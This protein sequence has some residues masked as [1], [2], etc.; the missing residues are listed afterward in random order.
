[1][2]TNPT[3]S[4]FKKDGAINVPAARRVGHSL[5]QK[6]QSMTKGAAALEATDKTVLA[7]ATI[8]AACTIAVAA[9]ATGAFAVI[10]SGPFAAGALGAVGLLLAARNTY[11]NRESA[12]KTLQPYVWSYIDDETPKMIDNS[13]R[14]DVGAAAMSL[15]CDGQ[16]QQKLADSKFQSAEKAFNEFWND[17]QKASKA[18]DML[19]GKTRQQKEKMEP[20]L[21]AAYRNNDYR[22]KALEKAFAQ[23]GAAYDFMRRL[24]HLGNYMQAPTVVGKAMQKDMTPLDDLAVKVQ[25][26]RDVRTKLATISSRIIS[27]NKTYDEVVEIIGG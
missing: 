20:V 17:Y 5:T 13:S 9:G 21:I 4:Q 14:N 7:G 15:I 25:G 26:V 19:T 3:F 27:D 22:K 8:N 24:I 12:H 18:L 23:G 10:A 11:S 2:P 6:F 16:A 1:M